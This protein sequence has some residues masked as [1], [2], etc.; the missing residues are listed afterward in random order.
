MKFIAGTGTILPCIWEITPLKK[1]IILKSNQLHMV[2]LIY[3]SILQL[4]YLDILR[5]V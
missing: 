1:R 4:S 2:Y 3:I 5:K